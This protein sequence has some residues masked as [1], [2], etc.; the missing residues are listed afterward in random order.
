MLQLHLLFTM[1][2]LTIH[3]TSAYSSLH[4]L[5]A[6]CALHYTSFLFAL[7]L[8][9]L[10]VTALR[11]PRGSWWRSLTGLVNLG[12]SCWLNAAVQCI[13]ACKPLARDIVD[14]SRDKGPLRRLLA[15]LF[16][17]LESGRWDCVSPFALLR[18]VYK[19]YSHLGVAPDASAD[20]AEICGWL[21]EHVVHATGILGGAGLMG[22]ECVNALVDLDFIPKTCYVKQLCLFLYI[23][24]CLFWYA[25][26]GDSLAS[27]CP[28]KPIWM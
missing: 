10:L 24:L 1:L 17:E 3:C 14:S 23:V 26:S 2:L 13:L 25:C 22:V 19:Q 15:D 20:C 12:D 8:L 27:H 4:L 7:L 16:A 21:L 28:R 11:P 9:H 5:F 18:Q 6:T